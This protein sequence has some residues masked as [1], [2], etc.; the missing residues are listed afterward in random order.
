MLLLP[1]LGVYKGDSRAQFEQYGLLSLD[2]L[3]AWDFPIM[4][5]YLT[6]LAIELKVTITSVV[7]EFSG[8]VIK[9]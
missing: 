9:H 1:K 5:A 8:A 6:A 7:V 3:I 4:E 2:S